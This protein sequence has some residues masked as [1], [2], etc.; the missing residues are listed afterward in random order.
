[1]LYTCTQTRVAA[2][3]HMLSQWIENDEGK[4]LCQMVLPWWQWHAI[5]WGRKGLL[6]LYYAVHDSSR[7]LVLWIRLTII[8][9]W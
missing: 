2:I 7:L 4:Y 8:V 3:F 6:L 5:L 1:M 9:A